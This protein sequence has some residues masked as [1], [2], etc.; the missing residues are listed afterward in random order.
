MVVEIFVTTVLANPTQTSLT[1]IEM[2]LETPARI[3]ENQGIDAKRLFTIVRFLAGLD[4]G[5]TDLWK[6]A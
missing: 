3:L 5:F 2:G 1:S 6:I 4:N